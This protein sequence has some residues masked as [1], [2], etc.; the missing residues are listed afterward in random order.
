MLAED[1]PHPAGRWERHGRSFWGNAVHEPRSSSLAA[2][3]S[4]PVPMLHNLKDSRLVT[5]A[6]AVRIVEGIAIIML[7]VVAAL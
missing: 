7:N 2:W 6:V 4:S 1:K 5:V 3:E